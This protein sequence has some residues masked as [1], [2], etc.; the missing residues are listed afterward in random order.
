MNMDEC[1]HRQGGLELLSDA[2]RPV[3]EVGGAYERQQQLD[4]LPADAGLPCSDCRSLRHRN[5]PSAS[6]ADQIVRGQQG[7]EGAYQLQA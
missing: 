7:S 4:A 3:V 6:D 1:A 2:A 5:N